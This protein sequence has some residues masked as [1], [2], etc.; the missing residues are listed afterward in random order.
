[1]T[2]TGLGLTYQWQLSDDGKT[3][4][5]SSV[6][7]ANYS[8]TL[9]AANHGR[10]VRWIV[11]DSS[12]DSVTS[13][14]AVM[15]IQGAS[16]TL[17]IT[18]QPTNYTGEIGSQVSFSVTATGLGLTY[19]WQLS[20]DGTNWRNSSTKTANYSTTLST[21]NNGRS[22]R[23]I[24][25]DS[26]GKSVTS[27][28]A[29]MSVKGGDL[30]ITEQPSNYAGEEGSQATFTVAA[31]GLGL[32]YQWQ[33]SDDGSNWSD[34]SNQTPTYTETLSIYNYG[35]RV[36]C[37]VTDAKGKSVTSYAASM[38]IKG[39]SAILAITEQPND[40]AGEEGSQAT[41]TV[42]ATGL[43][44]RYQW[45]V[46]DDGNNWS[47]TG[48]QTV[49][50]TEPLS[51]ANHGRNVRC[52]ITDIKARSITTNAATM[53]IV[54]Y[55]A[56]TK[57]PSDYVGKVGDKVS[58]TIKAEGTGLSYQWQVSE[59]GKT[60]T[61]TY[62]NRAT[63]SATLSAGN[64]GQRLRCIV[65]NSGGKS[66]TSH[67]VSMREIGLVTITEQP[68]SYAGKV[69]DKV[70]F[71]VKAVGYG[72]SYQWQTG[73]D[74]VNWSNTGVTATS[75]A[76]T[77]SDVNSG[78][79]VRCVVTD[80]DGNRMIS[81]TAQMSVKAP[82][83]ITEQPSDYVGV[84]KEEVKFRVVA[85]SDDT[86]SYQ[87]QLSDD[88]GKNWRNSS[89]KSANYTLMLNDTT[90]GRSFRCVISDTSGHELIS[91]AAQLTAATSF[92]SGFI[93]RNG[94]TKYRY[95]DGSYADGLTQINGKNYYFKSNVMKTGFL[96]LSGVYCYFDET[97]GEAVTGLRYVEGHG[98]YY[99]FQAEKGVWKGFL[100]NSEGVRYFSPSTGTMQLGMK[101]I[102]GKYYYF[103]T[104]TGLLRNGW[105]D[106]YN[107]E[108][109][110]TNTYYF[111]G[112]NGAVTGLHEIDGEWYNFNN[113]GIAKSG[114]FTID[115]AKY[116]FDE[117]SKAAIHGFY[118]TGYGDTYYF[119]EDGKAVSGWQNIDGNQYY[120]LEN[121]SMSRGLTSIN[122]K[123]YYFDFNTGKAIRQDS[124][125]WLGMNQLM[126]IKADG[127]YITGL[128]DIYG[129]LYYFSPKNGVA[130]SGIHEVSG[131]KY[132]FTSGSFEAVKGLVEY[133]GQTY[134][135]GGDYT[136]ITGLQ[137]INNH[138]Y[139]FG[140]DGAMRTGRLTI[141]GSV[142]YF[143]DEGKAVSGWYTYLDG[144]TYYFDETTH[145]A[146]TGWQYIEEANAKFYFDDSGV[147]KTG[148]V[149][150]NDNIYAYDAAGKTISGWYNYAGDLYYFSKDLVN[151]TGA[152][153]GGLKTIDG[154]LYYFSDTGVIQTGYK[155]VDGKYY[156]FNAN[157]GAAM[158]G[159]M[160]Q[161][162]NTSSFVCYGDNETKVLLTGSQTIDDQLYV[163]DS[164]GVMTEGTYSDSGN[165]GFTDINGGTGY[166]E[167]GSLVKGF[168]TIDGDTYYFDAK[169]GQMVSGLVCV[170]GKLYCFDTDGKR[171]TGFFEYDGRKYYADPDG[172][173]NTT[174]L[175]TVDGKTYCFRTNGEQVFGRT[176]IDSKVYYFDPATGERKLGFIEDG[177]RLYYYDDSSRGTVS[178]LQEINGK[179]YLFSTGDGFAYRGYHSYNGKD[180][181]FD[182]TTGESLSG[183][184]TKSNGKSYYFL[185]DGNIGYGLQTIGGKK[186]Y[187]YPSTGVK[188]DGLQSIGSKLYYF[189]KTNGMLTDQTVTVEGIQFQLA[190]DGSATVVG[191]SDEAKLLKAGL[192]YLGQPYKAEV[193]GSDDILSCSGLVRQMYSAI[194][195]SLEGSSYRQ[196]FNLSKDH[197]TFDS[198]NY[199]TPGDLVF[200]IELNCGRGDEC[201][202][203]GEIHH[204][205][206]YVGDGKIIEAN[207]SDTYSELSCI[208][209]QSYADSTT[210]FP[211]KV[212]KVL[213]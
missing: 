43:G 81:D 192:A 151:G 82:V 140:S 93:T 207:R 54:D 98:K 10:R 14:V 12:G 139:S 147:L 130:L 2:A 8:A 95:A 105:Y 210:Y 136:M 112:I 150:D 152:Y 41:F 169:S 75:Y 149:K 4:R 209:L 67:A 74:G 5:N 59:D 25:T 58:F 202:F 135:F 56:I 155:E 124:L 31:T 181:Y 148:L 89:V 197:Q 79:L 88:N 171:K 138:L 194:G 160:R 53:K 110:I 163:F 9:S 116:Y 69:G 55:L 103:D 45:Q 106:A 145:K 17:A 205:A 23:C 65:T 129:T 51:A 50:Y 154:E 117:L 133:N 90:N 100:E 3:W 195:I 40:Y 184:Y 33:I 190:S 42:T 92:T 127:G 73:T 158:T 91:E 134:Y 126:Y 213:D 109:N 168:K 198:I 188:I 13:D 49:T 11:T 104:H 165:V 77:L 199:A 174:G 6:K 191:D 108:K 173:I 120:F 48:N 123:R 172:V 137:T 102:D 16:N 176:Y 34:S 21:V 46:S 68:V 212:V 47:D 7:T 84:L 208:I 122:G 76:T 85:E 24:V 203:L 36:R 189:D 35:R 26:S 204:V 71:T 119:G 39:V 113:Y 38:T 37:V 1:M 32:S 196:Y 182:G 186:Y 183:I 52:V 128:A 30:A 66:L 153:R 167:D 125:I 29:M 180:Y 94:E 175:V 44:L 159:F 141:D 187:F 178:G 62:A 86:L 78:T 211:Y 177:D 27:S 87:W 70:T 185:G 157:T 64:N 22:V 162:T 142:Y 99:Y 131:K 114:L 143:D 19:Q 164:K 115:G 118:T 161:F 72:L 193:Q 132:Y 96:S 146:L 97:T 83:T 80:A 144:S 107:D 20:D 28:V 111:D 61:D 200:Y 63:Y 170:N 201:G 60:W 15:T 156:V 121:H 166:V 101:T 179:T 18:N 57:Q 206:M